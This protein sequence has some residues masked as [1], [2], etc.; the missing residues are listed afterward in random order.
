VS[1]VFHAATNGFGFGR[2]VLSSRFDVERD[3]P[4][5]LEAVA[6]D[7]PT[8][9]E[10]VA[11]LRQSL[12]LV[13]HSRVGAV[14]GFVRIPNHYRSVTCL[15]PSGESGDASGAIVFKGTEP[16]LPDLPEYFDWMLRAPFRGTYL[17]LGLH[18]PLDMK[19]PPG[20]MWIEECVLEQEVTSRIQREYLTQYGRLARLP[21]PLFVFELTTEQVERYRRVLRGRLSEAAYSRIEAKVAGGLGVEVYYYPTPPVRAADVLVTEVRNAFRAVLS[22]E[23]LAATFNDWIRLMA[24]LLALG[25]LPYAPWNHGMG[26]YVDPGN[27]CIDGGFNDLLTI[28]S[29]DSIPSE[30]LFWLGLG[31]SIEML[32]G[33]VVTMCSAAAD[34]GPPS[35]P[36]P[37]V[38]AVAY[39]TEGL[40]EHIRSHQSRSKALDP[41]TDRQLRLALLDSH[42]IIREIGRHHLRQR[43]FAEFREFYCSIMESGDHGRDTR[44]ALYGLGEVGRV[45]DSALIACD[46]SG[47]RHPPSGRR[48]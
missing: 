44:T 36:E 24:E 31:Q 38:A 42:A 9:R 33:S 7:F 27:A 35:Q 5:L 47:T 23:A 28:V 25:Y 22:G 13:P 18:F 2:T 21:V 16:L 45:E 19:L 6:S 40:R 26:A 15:I 34:T 46:S 4:R 8:I 20:A 43:G 14:G 17:P 11:S 3:T 39:V 12:P 32:A 10:I 41:R 1:D 30:S 48:R 29:F 37:P